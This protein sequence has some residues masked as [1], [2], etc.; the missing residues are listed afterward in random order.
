M[1]SL[2]RRGKF[3]LDHNDLHRVL[4]LPDDVRVLYAYAEMAPG[5]IHVVVE[6]DSLPP[7]QK[8]Q[9]WADGVLWHPGAQ[10]RVKWGAWR[11]GDGPPSA[12]QPS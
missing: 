9:S 1:S 6:G 4:G 7:N 12:V 8:P 3:V 2:P 10:Q 11:P 5:Q